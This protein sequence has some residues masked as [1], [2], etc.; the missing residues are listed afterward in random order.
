MTL[1]ILGGDPR[2]VKGLLSEC[3][4]EPPC[5]SVKQP[6]PVAMAAMGLYHERKSSTIFW[7]VIGNEV[8]V[9]N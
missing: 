4:C 6:D 8:T 7:K 5:D 2:N 3:A 9:Y 1:P